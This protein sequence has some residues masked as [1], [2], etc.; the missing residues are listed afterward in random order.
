M[1]AE[2]WIYF[3]KFVGIVAQGNIMEFTLAM[4][5]AAFSKEAYER[6]GNTIARCVILLLYRGAI[7]SNLLRRRLGYI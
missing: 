7:L 5:A 6:I 1:Q 2:S 3:V 4:V